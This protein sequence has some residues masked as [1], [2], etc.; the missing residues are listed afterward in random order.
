MKRVGIFVLNYNGKKFVHDLYSSL[1]A[2]TYKDFDIIVV[3]NASS[4]SSIDLIKNTFPHIKINQFK[5]NYGFA[6]AFNY[7]AR[8]Y[9]YEFILFLNNDLY[10]EPNWL[11][12]LMRSIERNK[13]ILMANCKNLYWTKPNFINSA[14]GKLTFL[15]T[16]TQLGNYEKNAEYVDQEKYIGMAQGCAMMVRRELFLK[17]GG[18]D[19][20]Y[21]LLGEEADICWRG[22]LSG[23]RTIYNP[24]SI[25]YHYGAYS[26]KQ[27]TW[28]FTEFQVTKNRYMTLLK[29]AQLRY[30]P[31]A[32]G[33][34]LLFDIT[35][36]IQR[37]E[38]SEIEAILKSFWYLIVNFGKI[39]KKRMTVQKLRCIEDKNLIRWGF[40]GTFWDFIQ[41]SQ[42]RNLFLKQL[43]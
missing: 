14:G 35:K 9:P 30:L 29:N 26:I 16:G 12:E 3:D 6:R 34:S 43:K 40:F 32:L 4:D 38:T 2:Q 15:G 5:Q 10:V 7:V 1:L 31:F 33:L 11:E 17:I 39:Y 20:Y 23:Y 19:T 37:R 25:L 21:F 41:V 28:F 27:K 8:K 36:I 42:K 22:W 18:F 13:L 24:K